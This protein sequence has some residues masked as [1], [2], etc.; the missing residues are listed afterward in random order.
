M[1]SG[2][3]KTAMAASEAAV[4]GVDRL[5]EAIANAVN[6][7][8]EEIAQAFVLECKEGDPRCIKL[9]EDITA[10]HKAEQI[11][12]ERQRRTKRSL[13]TEL[14]NEPEWTEEHEKALDAKQGEDGESLTPVEM[15]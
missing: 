7:N 9:A 12:L 14:A 4:Y 10:R 13:A 6:E 15:Q 11:V 5:R 3:L 8:A 1:S 2:E